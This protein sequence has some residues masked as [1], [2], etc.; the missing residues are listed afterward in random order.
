MWYFYL[1]CDNCIVRAI[2]GVCSLLWSGLES[3]VYVFSEWSIKAW[4]F[5]YAPNSLR[6]DVVTGNGYCCCSF[7]VYLPPEGGVLQCLF[8]QRSSSPGLMARA[9]AARGSR[10]PAWASFAP[11]LVLLLKSF[12]AHAVGAAMIRPCTY[13][14]SCSF[15]YN[16]PKIGT[17]PPIHIPGARP[18]LDP[19][20][21]A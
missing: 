15:S 2:V 14:N 10:G 3:A 19:R 6:T 13:D 18:S 17:M 12:D 9:G 11:E 16:R 20:M 4:H 5:F 7:T 1:P 21:E 8:G